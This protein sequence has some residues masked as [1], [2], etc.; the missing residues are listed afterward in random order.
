MHRMDQILVGC[1]DLQ[2]AAQLFDMAVDGSVGN[3]ALVRVDPGHELGSGK[4]LPRMGVKQ[5]EKFEF[6]GGQ[7]QLQP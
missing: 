5:L 3:N 1:G 2:L 6:H 7:I 4:E